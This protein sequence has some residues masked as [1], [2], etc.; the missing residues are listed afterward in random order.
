MAGDDDLPIVDFNRLVKKALNNIYHK[1]GGVGD[2]DPALFELNNTPLQKGIDKT[3]GSAGVEF[4]KK[5]KVFIDQFKHNT[6][7]FAAFK[8]HKQGDELAKLMLDEKGN[9]R[10]FSE[11]RKATEP[12]IGAYNKRY[13]KTEYDT[14]VRSARMATN[15]KKFEERKHIFPNIEFMLSRARD[16]R[17]EHRRYVGTILPMEHPW[18]KTHT[19]PIS[20][21]CECWIR[22]TRAA[23]KYPEGYTDEEIDN[24]IPEAFQNNPGI[25][26]EPIALDKHP[27]IT[28]SNISREQIQNFVIDNSS[29]QQLEYVRQE[30]IGVNNGY[31]DIHTLAD[32][33]VANRTIGEFL[34]NT[35]YKVRLLPDIDPKK[36]SLRKLLMPDGIKTN[37]NPDAMIGGRIFE[38]KTLDENTYNAISQE[39]RKAGGQADYILLNINGY[40]DNH[41]MKRA[42]RGR[43]S[44]KK[45][46]KEVWLIKDGQLLK[47]TRDYILGKAYL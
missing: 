25:T 23:V 20:W 6:S 27:Y 3:F 9:Q 8:S 2:I 13:L 24:D 10:S 26:G 4:G 1:R 19:P 46:I 44:M 38:F 37:K 12:L 17:P 7:I 36:V 45:N 15:W 28:E 43:I 32:K 39:L 42:I 40:M 29:S 31:L 41:L 47:Q 30:N 21:G 18:W 34:A 33:K 14:F 16:K 35:G 5:N 22:Q 11:F